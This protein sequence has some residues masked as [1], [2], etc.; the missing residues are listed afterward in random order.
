[1]TNNIQAETSPRKRIMVICAHPDD[2]ELTSGGV[3]SLLSQQGYE[4]L[5]VSVTNGNKGHYKGTPEQI[6]E[7][8]LQEMKDVEKML[9]VKYHVIGVD[10][11]ELEATLE[12]RYKV[13][14]VIR[15]WRPDIVITHPPYDYHP[16]H[17][18]TSILVQDASFLITVPKMLPEVPSMKHAPLFLY[19]RGRYTNPVKPIPDLV[20]DI[21]PVIEQKAKLINLHKS[22]IYEWLPFVNNL[23]TPN[24]KT[25]KDKV[26]YVIENY[27]LKRGIILPQ[28][29][30][31]YEKWYKQKYDSNKVKAIEAFEVSE[32]G[33]VPSEKELRELFG[34][35]PMLAE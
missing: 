15:E 31:V 2:V 34:L 14:K 35:F 23:P 20:V 10:D 22:Q 32:F 24:V 30:A 3:L 6:A 7:L 27:V 33:R 11:G 13:I 4:I 8:R 12:N 25:E 16:D 5:C 19:T 21:T 29:Q 1:M 18:N 9:G 28:D 26:N 17:R